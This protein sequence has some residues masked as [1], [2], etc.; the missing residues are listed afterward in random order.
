VRRR[1]VAESGPGADTQGQPKPWR[2]AQTPERASKSERTTAAGPAV[3]TAPQSGS[4]GFQGTPV[5]VGGES[6]TLR[7][8]RHGV[9]RRETTLV[10]CGLGHGG[11][12]PDCLQS[13]ARLDARESG[14]ADSCFGPCD[15]LERWGNW[16]RC[17]RMVKL[18][19]FLA[20]VWTF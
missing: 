7:P 3:A 2:G 5:T 15:G 13:A 6:P 17:E 11:A 20:A 8:E 1:G 4:T 18:L 14:R 16:I 12:R 10:F 9:A 19:R